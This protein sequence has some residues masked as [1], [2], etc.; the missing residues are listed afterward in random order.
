[1]A[2]SAVKF[3]LDK[4]APLFENELQLLRGVREEIL[5]LRG[6]LERMTAFLRVA[7]A[8]EESDAELKVWVKQLR[9]IA[10]ES[11]DVL[12]EFTLLQAHD[13]GEG[14][15]GSIHKLSCCIKNTKARYRIASELRAI[16]SRIKKI[17]EVHKRLRHKFNMAEQ[18]SSSKSA[19]YLLEDHRGDALLLEKTD[20]VGIDEPIKQ[21]VGRLFNGGC[22]REVVSAAGMGGMGK[23]TLAKQ[24]YDAAEVKKHFK[25]RAWI[26][27]T[28]S[29]RLAELLKDIVQQLHQAIRSPV[30]Q[31]INSMNTNQLKTIIKDFLQK[32]RY[33]IVLDDVWHLYGWDAL[34]YALPNYIYGSRVILTTRNAYIASTTSTESG[35]EVYT[36]KPLPLVESWELL[37]KKTFQGNSCPPHLEKICNYVLR[38]CEGLPLAI[39]AIS[40]VLAAKDKR[41]IDEW[42]MVGHSL[43]AEIEGN[44]KLQDLKK[45]LSLS[46]NDLPYNL[47]SC[48]LYLSIFPEDHLIKHMR[49]I[50]L[51]MAEGFI[52]EKQGKTLEEVAEDY[53]NEL[54]NRSMIQ[55]A[56][57]TADGRVTK[58]R[59]HDL[60]R[61]IITSKTRS[62]N[63]ATIAKEQNVTLPEKIRRLSIHNTLQY[64]QTNRCASQLRSLFMFT[65]AEKPSLQRL[66]P[67]GFALLNVLDLQS[68]PLNVFPVEL[69]NLY[70][71]KYQSL[72]DTRLATAIYVYNCKHQLNENH[73]LHG[74]SSLGSYVIL[75]LCH[76]DPMAALTPSS[77]PSPNTSNFI[78]L[79]ETNY[80]V[81]LFQLKPFLNGNNLWGYID[82][83][84]S[85]PAP[86]IM[87]TP[88][89]TQQATPIPNPE[90]KKWFQQDQLIVS[91][92][93]TTL[94]ENIAQLTIGFETA[95]DIW[96]CLA[97]HFSQR[98][99][100]SA[101][102]LKLQL[103]D[104]HKGTQSVD[105]YLRHAKSI[106][107]SLSSINKPVP[108]EDLVLAT[109]HG[110]GPDYLMLRTALTQKSPLP[111]FTELR[112]RILS[113]DAS[114]S[115]PSDST[116]V[117][118]LYHQS[119]V[120][121]RRDNRSHTGRNFPRNG[122]SNS[123][124][125]YRG[126]PSQIAASF[127]A[128]QMPVPSLGPFTSP[129]W[130]VR[131]SPPNG[132]LGPAPTWCP[133][134]HTNQH[135]LHQCPHR[136][137][138]PS[139]TA[140]FAGAH[141]A[142]DPNWYPD[143]GATHHMTAMPLN[144]SQPYGGPHN[145]YMGNGDSMPI[146]H[147]GTLPFS[148]GSSQFSLSDVFLIPS[149]GKNLLSVAR[150]TKDNRVFFLFAPDF[151]QIYCL[152]T[153]RLLFQGPCKDGLYPL[154]LSSVS[155][156]PY[157][158][159]STH[160]TIWHNR[161]GHPSSN[162][163]A[164]IGS[165][166][167]SK[168]SFRSFC[169]D[170][171]LSKSHQFP[172][173]SNNA[174]ATTL[175]H[176]IHSDVWSSSTSS[177]SGFKYYVLFT[178]E[179]SRYTWIYPVRRK[180]EVLTHF[181]TFVAMI[182][183]LFHHSIKFLQSDNGTEYVSYAFSNYCN[184][185][186]I[187]QRFSCP[188]TPQQNGL[189]ER[190]HLHIATMARALLLTSGT[191]HNLWV[192]AVLTSVYLINLLPT[193]VLDWDT[194][195]RR[196]YGYSPK[197]KG[198]RCLDP[199]SDRVYVSR[200]VLFDETSFPY[201]KLQDP[202]VQVSKA[203]E[204]TQLIGP[205]LIH[206]AHLPSGPNARPTSSVQRQSSTSLASDLVAPPP[207]NPPL[208]PPVITYHRRPR[209]PSAVPAPSLPPSAVPAAHGITGPPINTTT[210]SSATVAPDRLPTDGPALRSSSPPPATNPPPRHQMVTRLQDGTQKPRIPSDGTVR[211]P[212][213]RAL[214]T[215]V[216]SVEPTC[217]S[218]ASKKAEWHAAMV[219]EINALMKNN[220]WSLVP[221]SLT[222]NIVGCKWVFKVKRK[223]DGSVERFKARL[224]A[225][226]VKNAFLHGFL[227]EDVYMTQ[228]PGFIDQSHPTHVCKLNKS[229]YGLKQAPWA[230]FQRMT[231]FLLS[232]GFT[233]S[234][235]DSSLFIFAHGPHTIYFLLYVD[236]IV[237][238]SSH[239][240]LL[241]SFIDALSRGFD[242][243]DLGP[244]HYFLGLQVHTSSHGLHLNQVKYAHDLLSKH[245]MLLTKPMSTPMSAKDSLTAT[246]GA[247]LDNPTEFRT[248]V[249]ALQYLTITRPDIAFAVNSV[250]QFMSQPRL[251]H[252]VAVKRILR[253]VK[254]TLGHG[255][256]FAPQHQPVHLFAYSDADWAGCP[257]SRRSTSVTELPVEILKLQHL[258]YLLVY[259]YEFVPYKDFHST[260]G[261][262]VLAK[263]RALKSLQK[264][265]FI[266]VN[267]GGSALL[268]ELGKLVQLRRLGIVKMR[269]KDGKALSSSIE[270][271]SK[272]YALSITSVEEDEIIDLQHLRS[273]PLLLQH[274]YLRGRLEA[275]PH[276]IPS[277]HSL[278]KLYLKWSRLR[279]DPLGFLQYLPNL[280]H[281]ELCQVFE[282]DTLCFGAG[283]FKKL[284]HLCLDK[285]NELRCIEMEVG[286]MPCIE[287]LIIR[288][289]KSLEK[290]PSGIE[291]LIKLKLLKF[292]DMPEKLIKTLLPHEHG[293]DYWK[294]AHV[295]EVY[296]TYLREFG[297]EVFSL[298]GL[299]ETQIS[300][301]PSSV[302]K[303]IGTGWK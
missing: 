255:L 51:W 199:T 274:L 41:R 38:K 70:F 248:L 60:F 127:P 302:M 275:L 169:K 114:Q 12:D 88:S 220:T 9:D 48:F 269:K 91:I 157:A 11:E 164:R 202:S 142:T 148:L 119:Q 277:L 208:S 61:E 234:L 283:G 108:D 238:T 216:D 300:S 95:K 262:K 130:A 37:C 71:L 94:T 8:Y 79:T 83:S 174:T 125:S 196:L 112:A 137:P 101:A 134:G 254:G 111:D 162:V 163:F 69:V 132:L 33:L 198:Y 113:F 215:M 197:H 86:T 192:E 34:K 210:T 194:P 47:K 66:F 140:P 170:C 204:L 221:S 171:A 303:S 67:A 265:C 232:I 279:D 32:R 241:Q 36:L 22:G 2:E 189:A 236:D 5:H 103:L 77:A 247:L 147:T 124:S 289:C 257:D 52:E 145:V 106:A 120:S 23:T 258:P 190:K 287:N 184:S 19:G 209:P 68:T 201:R 100:A 49:L 28:Q 251:P 133:N 161:L 297:W 42:E 235:A 7:D 203:L 26:T 99:V 185:L 87:S 224:V 50:R 166:I 177:V 160:S 206:D 246:D 153:G 14:L 278:V 78:K 237:V 55:A 123:G 144:H 80:L 178:D 65:V 301:Q 230:W 118:A 143:T 10:H 135:G 40:G 243:K 239:D 107:D 217:Y 270:K 30:P 24:V 299:S 231:S 286:T 182:Q 264:L 294:V 64:V 188:H 183:N 288:R 296:V 256:S 187:Q 245:D 228:P 179:F 213:P 250:S 244:L 193:P 76:L 136:F 273:P 21:M 117:T 280:V 291:H 195:H 176:I 191:P 290:V 285:S 175:F 1:M 20:I 105:D 93:T 205:V 146:S 17:S 155:P 85:A 211:Y 74:I 92:L 218:Q 281:L 126:R 219:D 200:H 151:Y 15:Y 295:P 122:R 90:Y 252:L 240:R 4:L 18:G 27:F 159:T 227:T 259:R 141:F 6:E 115:R 35:G 276:W 150:F 272:L 54:L 212:I 73:F 13:H 104:L 168:L 129:A 128:Q 249:G 110:L 222:Q 25:L 154:D 45:V 292:F 149:I 58:F 282:G 233:Q 165:S 131:P 56:E 84:K 81:W 139:T 229:L 46:F 180:N 109:L 271:L 138:G 53:L 152:L 98:S 214:L 253:Y 44:D 16:N 167:G 172:F 62:Q 268:R 102:N 284:K 181:Q 72:R 43:G 298:E 186:G 263:I 266:E 3:L 242:I 293:N 82:G 59:I 260:Y 158:L 116:P 89:D 96:D 63:F 29:F 207:S 226:D 97:R 31:E 261:F 223:P 267:Q 173:Q 57:T 39:V 156:T 75:L 121:S 225:K